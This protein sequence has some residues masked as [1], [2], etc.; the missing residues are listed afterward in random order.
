MPL[1][2]ENTTFTRD[3][4]GRY[5]CNTFDEAKNTDFRRFNIVVIGG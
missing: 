3:V 1:L 2:T 4:Q 5:V